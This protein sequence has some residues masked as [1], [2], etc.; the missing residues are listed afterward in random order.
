[1]IP[2]KK[3]KTVKIS[4]KVV[5]NWWKMYETFYWF[6]CRLFLNKG[7]HRRFHIDFE[8]SLIIPKILYISLKTSQTILK[9]PQI[10]RHIWKLEPDSVTGLMCKFDTFIH[11]FWFCLNTADPVEPPS[12]NSIS[13][14][15]RQTGP[16]PLNRPPPTFMPPFPNIL[17]SPPNVPRAPMFRIRLPMPVPKD[18][19]EDFLHPGIMEA[20]HWNGRPFRNVWHDN[21]PPRGPPTWFGPEPPF[22][23]SG[24][25][26]GGPWGHGQFRNWCSKNNP[27]NI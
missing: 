7:F 21:G 3:K 2:Q 8:K 10:S 12:E 5:G 24:W 6:L 27:S 14:P 9:I 11:F 1:M 26:R 20:E 23:H 16:L 18:P 17:H 15:P 22:R 13:S 25:S 19:A 4:V